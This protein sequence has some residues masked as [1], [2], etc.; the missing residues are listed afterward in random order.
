[1]AI[2]ERNDFY[3]GYAKAEEM[4][5]KP[6]FDFPMSLGYVLANP[7][8]DPYDEGIKA[9]LLEEEKRLRKEWED[10]DRK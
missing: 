2:S 3:K 9:R 1:M 10:N 8:Y 6:R 7:P 5:R 4:L